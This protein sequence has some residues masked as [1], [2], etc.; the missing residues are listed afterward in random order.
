[1]L[2]TQNVIVYPD[3]VSS[4]APPFKRGCL[5]YEIMH[6]CGKEGKRA[7]I[8]VPVAGSAAHSVSSRESR[9]SVHCALCTYRHGCALCSVQ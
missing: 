2:Q 1:M 8:Q 7:P 5:S 9:L 6:P 3:T 4:S